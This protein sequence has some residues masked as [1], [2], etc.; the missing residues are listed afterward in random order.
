MKAR[1]PGSAIDLTPAWVTESLGLGGVRAVTA[2]P[3]GM[4]NASTTIRLGV[5]WETPG[6][7]PESFVVKLSAPPGSEQRAAAQAWNAY[8]VEAM[9]YTNLAPALTADIPRC[10]WAGYEPESGSYAVALEDLGQLEAGDDVAGGNVD[11]AERALAEIA[12]VHG[13]RWGDPALAGMM[14]LN[15]YPTGQGGMLHE[16]MS[17]A[18][19]RLDAAYAEDLA[20]EVTHFVRRFAELANRYDRKGFGGPRTISHGDFRDDNL[21]F[22]PDRVC[23]VDWQTVQLGSG[24]ADVAYYLAGSLRTEDRRAHEQDLVRAYQERLRKQGVDLSWDTCWREYRRHGL[25]LLTTALKTV[26]RRAEL[27]ARAR[28]MIVGMLQR[29]A[30][31]AIDLESLELLE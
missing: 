25:C 6:A 1:V 24:P 29:S 17:A 12:L 2:T 9:F 16:E 30:A 4:G 22:G 28:T 8:E 20:P 23:V 21:M 5:Q 31:Q 13:P 3:V 27:P 15:R 19:D 26:G 7:A 11:R 18:A 14:W 10:Y